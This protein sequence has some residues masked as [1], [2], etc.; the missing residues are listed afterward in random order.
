MIIDATVVSDIAK[1][2]D[3]L[4]QLSREEPTSIEEYNSIRMEFDKL[5]LKLNS[6][7]SAVTAASL[8]QAVAMIQQQASQQS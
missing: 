5:Q 7:Q 8:Q 3:R 1:L 2:Q 4:V 6:L